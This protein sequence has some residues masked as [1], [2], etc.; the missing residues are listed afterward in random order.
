MGDKLLSGACLE[1]MGY[2]RFGC[3]LMVLFIKMPLLKLIWS[4]L[5]IAMG[6]EYQVFCLRFSYLS[7]VYKGV[8]FDYI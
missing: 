7:F 4:P 8:L 6:N 2:N 3:I 1:G 5:W